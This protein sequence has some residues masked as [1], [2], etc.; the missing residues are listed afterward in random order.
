MDASGVQGLSCCEA[1]Q[2]D[3]SVQ[4]HVPL[5]VFIPGN[6]GHP[7][8]CKVRAGA[9]ERERCRPCQR[10]IQER[11]VP[12]TILLVL[13]PYFQVPG[14]HPSGRAWDS[15]LEKSLALQRPPGGA[16]MQVAI[17]TAAQ[18]FLMGTQARAAVVAQA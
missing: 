6:S 13:H 3:N 9:E 11:P 5:E 7:S 4:I 1:T 12:S 10:A 2:G 17:T 14:A 18:R 15:G 8:A 16:D